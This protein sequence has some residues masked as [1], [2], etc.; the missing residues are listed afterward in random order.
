MDNMLHY[1]ELK[2]ERIWQYF[3][4]ALK[5]NGAKPSPTFWNSYIILIVVVVCLFVYLFTYLSFPSG[6]ERQ[7]IE[8]SPTEWN[9]KQR[10]LNCFLT[11]LS[12][13]KAEPGVC[14]RKECL[15]FCGCL[16]YQCVPQTVKPCVKIQMCVC[17]L[18]QY[19]KVINLLKGNKSHSQ[20]S[21]TQICQINTELP[22]LK[23]HL[24]VHPHHNPGTTFINKETAPYRVTVG[25]TV[26]HKMQ[27]NVFCVWLKLRLILP[28]KSDTF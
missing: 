11:C 19:N 12:I 6:S 14:S 1:L 16:L 25:P 26:L 21:V 20:G 28:C 15:A 18:R 13:R 24:M 5:Y 4:F 7:Q 23:Y 9:K 2:A 8:R 17:C 22:V 10:P 27:L 3:K